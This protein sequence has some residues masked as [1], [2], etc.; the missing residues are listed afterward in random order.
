MCVHV[1]KCQS[2]KP[3]IQVCVDAAGFAVCGGS[4]PMQ[5]N[6][7]PQFL[8]N[9]KK[10]CFAFALRVFNPAEVLIVCWYRTCVF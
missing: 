9:D 4:G 1:V 7:F 2:L 8:R 3:C 6:W 5:A 10:H